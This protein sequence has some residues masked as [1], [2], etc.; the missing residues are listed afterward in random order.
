MNRRWIIVI[1]VLFTLPL[2]VNGQQRIPARQTTVS[3]SQ[4]PKGS[5]NE[6]WSSYGGTGLDWRYSSLNQINTS[7]VKALL[8]AWIFQSGDYQDALQS[9]PIVID[10]I[11]YLSSPHSYVFALDAATGKLLWQYK[12]EPL[13]GYSPPFGLKSYG[14][15]VSDGKVFIGTYDDFIVALD[16]KTGHEVWKVAA[17]DPTTCRCSIS[18]APLLVKDKVVIGSSGSRGFVAAFNVKTGHMDWRF[19]TVP[20]AGEPG[21]ETWSGDMWKRGGVNPWVTG[22]YDSELNLVYWGMGDPS[23]TFYG[24]SR[25]GTNLYGDSVVAIDADTGK[26][27]WYHQE[28]PHDTWD[29][30]S[31]WEPV[32]MDREVDGQMRKLM[33][34]I[35]K[36]GYT[37]VLDRTN[38]TLVNIYQD[39]KNITWV[40]QITPKGEFIGRHD[41]L[42][43]QEPWLV[44]PSNLGGKSWNHTAYSPRTTFLYVPLIE[45]CNEIVV[46]R[47]IEGMPNF[48]GAIW[49]M[50]S[51]PGHES[52]YSHID[53]INPVTGKL[54]WTYQYKYIFL[55]SMLATGGDLLFTGDPEGEFFALDARTGR[56][57]WSYQNGAGHRGSPVTYMVKGRQY[58]AMPTGWGTVTGEIVGVLWPESEKWRSGSSLVVFALP[59]ESK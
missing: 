54:Q 3:Q 52:A 44:C 10:G 18:S 11:M 27:C 45:V 4:I 38:G 46:R 16:Q 43:G 53:A 57:L 5:T 12:H 26:L 30:D 32:L 51:P 59:K 40:K 1:V 36:S 56:K 17:E 19:F 41:V 29:Y 42:E 20:A 55:A 23:P 48:G 6:N 34:H 9:T 50:K 14:V 24:G 35:N 25:P 39:N 7:N 15:A 33:V 13:P 2:F 28:I 22:S 49:V 37:W 31:N 21:N 58:V 8:P 47:R